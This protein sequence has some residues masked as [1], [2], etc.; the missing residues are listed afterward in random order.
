MLSIRAGI[1]GVV[2]IVGGQNQKYCSD[3]GSGMK[4][5]KSLAS[6]QKFTVLPAPNNKV[7][8]SITGQSGK[9]CS[10]RQDKGDAVICN[11]PH[12][13][14]W[15]HFTQEENRAKGWTNLK[16]GA[17]NKYCSD[18]G[19]DGVKCDRD[20]PDVWE[21]FRIQSAHTYTS[22]GEGCCKDIGE[23]TK[24]IA[25]KG[26]NEGEVADDFTKCKT[27]CDEEESCHGFHIS[28]ADGWCRIFEDCAATEL[29]DASCGS[30][31]TNRGWAA[32]SMNPTSR[33]P[34]REILL[35]KMRLD[36]EH[37]CHPM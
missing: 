28:T 1:T 10:D 26:G 23:G 34:I 16:G 8:I 6:T 3:R 36:R 30:V 14:Q 25:G 4:C 33:Q 19:S 7:S 20:K 9:Y 5:D 35:V 15:E 17:N 2:T 18:T 13:L 27:L 21:Q 24:M 12:S 29:K 11:I 22:L 31:G 32:Y 37:V